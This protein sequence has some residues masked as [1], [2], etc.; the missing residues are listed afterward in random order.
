MLTD[1]PLPSISAKLPTNKNKTRKLPREYPRVNQYKT[2]SEF[3]S[4]Q[5]D[6]SNLPDF[7]TKPDPIFTDNSYAKTPTFHN[8]YAK[9]MARIAKDNRENPMSVESLEGEDSTPVIEP[10]AAMAPSF[11]PSLN[12]KKLYDTDI[13]KSI[14][15]IRGNKTP[16][17]PPL[18][19]PSQKGGKRKTRKSKKGT[20]KNKSRKHH[21]SSKK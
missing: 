18:V 12:R 9:T 7:F 10:S 2:Q 5:V 11:L 17:L 14:L 3:S 21:R 16:A 13:E 20:R 8:E 4:R 1:S 19:P 6:K 15:N